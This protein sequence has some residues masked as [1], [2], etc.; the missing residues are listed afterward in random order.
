[1][2]QRFW[3]EI[4]RHI[5]W[6]AQNPEV[7]RLRDGGDRRVTLSVFPY[8]LAYIVRDSVIRILSV[9][10]DRSLPEYWIDRS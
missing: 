4:D 3:A 5:T 7:P 2:G 6:I 8:Y 1:L 9:V 10:H